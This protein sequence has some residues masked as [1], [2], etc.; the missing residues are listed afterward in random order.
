MAKEKV[1][2]WELINKKGPWYEKL[3]ERFGEMKAE[4]I[5]EFLRKEGIGIEL[6]A[7]FVDGI[8]ISGTPCMKLTMLDAG[9]RPI[10]PGVDDD[11]IKNDV[12]RSY[13]WELEVDGKVQKT[14]K[15]ID[16]SLDYSLS[17]VAVA[18]IT[19]YLMCKDTRDGKGE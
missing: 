15:S 5:I 18:K 3:R 13:R 7:K 4:E 14:V 1:Q 10:Q 2:N 12:C 19:Y 8:T 11:P 16:L 17:D 6:P 9:G